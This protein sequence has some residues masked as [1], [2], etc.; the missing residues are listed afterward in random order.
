MQHSLKQ[1]LDS[2]DTYISVADAFKIIK[3]KTDLKSDID[4]ARL[5]FENK[6]NDLVIPVNKYKYFDGKPEPLYKDYQQKQLTKMDLLLLEIASGELS[7]ESDN[8]ARLNNFAWEKWDFFFE[9][10][11]NF[12][13]DLEAESNADQVESG[14]PFYINLLATN[15]YFTIVEAACLISLD[16]P[17]KITALIENKSY[18]YDAWRYGE[19]IQAVRIIENG[20]RA[21]K[22]DIESDGM[23]PRPSLQRFLHEKGHVIDGFNDDLQG[24]ELEKNTDA[25]NI[26]LQQLKL[27][28]ENLKAEL[29]EKDQ[30]NEELKQQLKNM[31]DE[32]LNLAIDMKVAGHT[33]DRKAAENEKLKAELAEKDQK[34]KELE[35]LKPKDDMDLLSLIFDESAK[36]IYAPDLVFAIKAWK[37]I[38]I[39]NP[40]TDSHNNKANTWI[41]KNTPYSGEQE[42]T[43]TRRLREIISPFSDWRDTRKKLLKDS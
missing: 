2:S 17:T 40:K 15:D 6:I 26:E 22:L 12:K 32:N 23:I 33:L 42:D 34:I 3:K 1:L 14:L 4:I 43:P 36:E 37:S 38:Y 25:N 9:F 29:A 13:I 28:N 8:D 30:E 18:D 20:I 5:L 35:S 24:A 41:K 19:H 27:E 16:E 21:N 7:V 10:K 39:D 31:E 11:H